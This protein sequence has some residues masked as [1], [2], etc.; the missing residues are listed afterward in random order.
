[1]LQY[2][3]FSLIVIA[4]LGTTLWQVSVDQK[5][6]PFT[7]QFLSQISGTLLIG[8]TLSLLHKIVV[9]R[10]ADKRLRSLLRIH[11]S[12]DVSGLK[13]ILLDSKSFNFTEMLQRAD[14]LQVV[15]NDGERWV[16]TYSVELERR[17]CRK[18]ATTIYIT[19]PNGKFADALAA[20][21]GLTI[22]ELQGKISKMEA[23][24]KSAYNR[25]TKQGTLRIFYLKNY[26]TQSIF[27]SEDLVVITPY[28]TSGGRRVVPLFI[29]EDNKDGR[30]YARDVKQDLINVAT[31]S[32]LAFKSP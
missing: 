26:P 18:V 8:G 3:I 16:G 7:Y 31:E 28:Q 21:T 10:S 20:K 29:Y 24:L 6:S 14:D 12:V 25:S 5:T 27:A 9:D 30:C 17:F 4:G 19:D 1:M 23:T 32:T 2:I 15:M 13:E 22:A 11:D